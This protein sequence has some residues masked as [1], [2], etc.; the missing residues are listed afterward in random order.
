MMAFGKDDMIPGR[1]GT[2]MDGRI[3]PNKN[4]TPAS[5]RPKGSFMNS[6]ASK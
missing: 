5:M 3:S 6:T 2:V 4:A 1:S